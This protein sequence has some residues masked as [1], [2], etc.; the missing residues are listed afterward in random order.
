M[1]HKQVINHRQTAWLV[2]NVLLTGML[3]SF[4]HSLAGVAKMDAWFS[5]VVP[6]GY[7]ILVAFVLAEMTRAYPGKNMFEIVFIIFGKWFGGIVNIVILLYIWLIICLD[8]KGASKFFHAT[9]LPQTPIE[10]TL[11]VLVLLIMYYGKTSLEIAARVNEMY[12]PVFFLLS[13]CMYVLLGNEYS[14]ERLEPILSTSMN[15]LLVS[16]IL[17]VGIY[18]DIFLFGAFLHASTHPRLFF[19]AMKH[20]ILIVGFTATMLLLILLGV[21]GYTIASRLNFPMFILVQQIHVTDFLDR[22]EIVMFSLWF[23]AFAIKVVVAYLAFLVGIGSFGGQAHYPIYN[24]PAGWMIAVTSILLFQRIPDLDMFLSYSLPLVVLILQL[25]LITIFYIKSR[26]N[27]K[28][29]EQV[30]MPE[31]TKL[32]RFFRYSVW[33]GAIAMLGCVLTILAGQFFLDK[34]ELGGIVTGIS[35]TVLFFIA[36]LASYAEM[37]ALNH[38][39]QKT[40]RKK[41]SGAFRQ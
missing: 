35:F 18:G 34:S 8:I 26:M 27:R 6:V 28:M 2:G 14:F 29:D 19:S 32:Y 11:I 25:P 41:A 1:I 15:R 39:K 22:V 9:L 3:I 37:Q 13:M 4:F 23:P 5:Q 16:N 24:F 7:A 36:L 12:F 30:S 31:G 21:M 17:P 10:I 38:G 33:V 40:A 20:G